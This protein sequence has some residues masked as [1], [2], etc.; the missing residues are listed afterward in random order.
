MSEEQKQ[1]RKQDADSTEGA[2]GAEPSIGQVSE[3]GEPDDKGHIVTRRELARAAAALGI[4][5]AEE[6]MASGRGSISYVLCNKAF[7][8][9]VKQVAF[10]PGGGRLAALAEGGGMLV[11]DS[12]ILGKPLDGFKSSN[13]DSFLWGFRE[14]LLVRDTHRVVRCFNESGHKLFESSGPGIKLAAFSPSGNWL[15]LLDDQNALQMWDAA[16][17]RQVKTLDAGSTVSDHSSIG[18]TREEVPRVYLVGRHDVTLIDSASGK[19]KAYPEGMSSA[20]VRVVVSAS[21]EKAGIVTGRRMKVLTFPGGQPWGDEV[22][23]GEP[24]KLEGLSPRLD[25]L[26]TVGA[27]DLITVRP[28]NAGGTVQSV[29]A[30][31]KGVT[32]VTCSWD[33]MTYA[34]GGRDG[35][36]VVHRASSG[37][38]AIDNLAPAFDP[39]LGKIQEFAPR[40]ARLAYRDCT[41]TCNS[42]AVT[43][44]TNERMTQVW[45]SERQAWF[46]RTMPCGSP[47]PAGSICVCNCVSAASSPLWETICTCNTVCT[48]NT[49]AGSG[50]YTL[51][52][53]Y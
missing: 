21:S 52:Y 24:G 26:V 3:L 17:W 16:A 7:P 29:S 31:V 1:S 20:S 49:Q 35:R 34:W 11:W 46:T 33:P 38:L 45:D 51:R 48:C 36:V 19:M 42:V 9:P 37:T 50:G 23:L 44:E 8:A 30:E 25:H 47:I 15:V 5:G 40:R 6:A 27:N 22:D 28:L 4:A 53:W 43:S 18:V 14:V 32:C 2:Q 10:S 12:Q 13:V 41:C 39:S